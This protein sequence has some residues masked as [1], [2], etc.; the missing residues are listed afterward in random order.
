MDNS[1]LVFIG[2]LGIAFIFLR[3]LIAPI[4]PQLPSELNEALANSSSN[5]TGSANNSRSANSNA[6]SDSSL[7]NITRRQRREV[8]DDMIEVVQTIAPQL[9]RGQ[10]RMD[11][12]RTGSVEVTIERY[13][14]TGSLPFPPGESAQAQSLQP[15]I[16]AHSKAPK[17]SPENLIKKYGLDSKVDTETDEDIENIEENKWGA[18][19]EERNSLLNKKREEMILQA[20]RRLASQL[21]NEVAL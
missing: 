6:Y 8:S 13:M 15:D 16:S 1:T 11:L 12:E 3:W 9:T 10:I 17:K 2:V 5:N 18:N 19:K 21:Q 4:P 7:Q 20:R 14:E